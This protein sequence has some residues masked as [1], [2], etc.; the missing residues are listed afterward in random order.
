MQTDRTSGLRSTPADDSDD[1]S[2]MK[3]RGTGLIL[4][5]R[6][7]ACVVEESLAN[8]RA[9]IPRPSYLP[10]GAEAFRDRMDVFS[11]SE[12]D[13]DNRDKDYYPSRGSREVSEES[14]PIQ[15]A[16]RSNS[17]IQEADRP[18]RK[19]AANLAKSLVFR[20]RGYMSDTRL[21]SF[22]PARIF[23]GT[24][25]VPSMDSRGR[26]TLR[27]SLLGEA[28]AD[29]KICKTMGSKRLN[30]H[31]SSWHRILHNTERFTDLL[32]QAKNR[33]STLEN[34]TEAHFEEVYERYTTVKE[35][36]STGKKQSA[37]ASEGHRTPLK[38]L[39]PMISPDG[40][41]D[42][43]AAGDR[44]GRIDTLLKEQKC[45]A[46]TMQVYLASVRK[47][48][49]W[50]SSDSSELRTCN[51][52]CEQV[53]QVRARCG[54][55][56]RSLNDDVAQEAIDEGCRVCRSQ[57]V[58]D[59]TNLAFEAKD[60]TPVTVRQGSGSRYTVSCVNLGSDTP[61]G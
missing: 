59:A 27:C 16:V 39:L 58:K 32:T 57:V 11:K 60:K 18:V 28:R 33:L 41:R 56:V 43:M 29:G 48:L 50:L 52:T 45:R 20:S 46:R 9:R 22:L 21:D 34:M 53:E 42:L 47:F 25:E 31:L 23:E 37:K 7:S 38:T 2:S 17:W 54:M 36:R 3:P 26:A 44:G 49:E 4:P 6:A 51:L 14:A 35:G 1:D 40:L 8:E 55:F 13:D 19:C 30:Q 12:L 61:C 5:P 24:C 15:K 10:E